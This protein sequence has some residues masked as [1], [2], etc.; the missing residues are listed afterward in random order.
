MVA[1]G[2]I[3]ANSQRH[4]MGMRGPQLVC[5]EGVRGGS[6]SGVRLRLQAPLQLYASTD[7]RALSLRCLGQ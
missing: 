3:D 7:F 1:Y 4:A 6:V 2:F 5:G